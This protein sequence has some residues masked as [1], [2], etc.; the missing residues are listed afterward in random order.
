VSVPDPID[1]AAAVIKR[2]GYV[3]AYANE[4]ARALAEAG[5]LRTAE[6]RAVIEAAEH[7]AK[8]LYRA[9][10]RRQGIGW[11][12]FCTSLLVESQHDL[13]KAL[14]RRVAVAGSV[15]ADPEEEP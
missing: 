1:A 2:A 4:I 9:E 15:P 12:D 7:A 14:T 8:R 5:W 3:N 10:V 13:A 11:D 6:D